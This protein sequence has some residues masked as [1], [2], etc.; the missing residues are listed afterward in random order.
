MRHDHSWQERHAERDSPIG[1]HHPMEV[2][3]LMLCTNWGPE[4]KR[5]P[6]NMGLDTLCG[7][8]HVHT[9][10]KWEKSIQLKQ[11]LIYV[12]K[13]YQYEKSCLC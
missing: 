12:F 2:C 1:L 7:L 9:V 13:T 11:N 5:I 8:T 6:H 3:V 10:L 4:N